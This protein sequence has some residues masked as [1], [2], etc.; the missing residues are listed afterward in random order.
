MK[1][2]THIKNRTEEG[3]KQKSILIKVQTFLFLK[4]MVHQF[5]H[6]LG[7]GHSARQ[8]SVMTPFYLDWVSETEVVPD[9]GDMEAVRVSGEEL[10]NRS[11]RLTLA[12]MLIV[13][14]FTH[15]QL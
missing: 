7:L 13:L 14:L 2:W 8:T 15:F 11:E 10:H 12:V 4:V 9:P 3:Y 1:C 6:M 5:G